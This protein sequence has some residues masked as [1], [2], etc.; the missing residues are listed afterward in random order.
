VTERALAEAQS[1]DGE[2]HAFIALDPD[3][4]RKAARRADEAR[5]RGH[6]LRPLHGVPL[7][8]KDLVRT[9]KLPTTGGS[10]TLGEGLSGERE[11][12]LVERLRSAGAVI[13]GKTNL[14]EFAYGV[15][16]ENAHFGD[17][18]N[19]WDRG[20]MSG[21]SSGGSAV[22]V[23]AGI[24]PGAVGTDTRG[25]IRIPASCCGITGFKPTRGRIPT[26]GVIP[27]SRSM[28]HVGPMARSVED[29]S[30]LYQVMAGG[31]EP[32]ERHARVMERPVRGL[33][34]GLSPYFRSGLHPDVEGAFDGAL[35]VLAELGLE[36]LEVAIPELEGSLGSSAVIAA[37]EALAV[38]DRRMRDRREAF[39]PAVLARLERGR[40]LTALELAR[41]LDHRRALSRAYRRVF[42]KVD[43]MVTPTLP[44]LPPPSGS[45]M[46]EAAGG[47]E[48]ILSAF[49][50]LLAPQNMT[51]TPA[52]S[53]PCGFSGTGLPIGLQLCAA[54]GAGE[55]ALAAGRAFQDVTDW[56]RHRPPPPV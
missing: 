27:L 2:L 9:R 52:L 13:L 45:D 26:H 12:R 30:L 11:A 54:A 50:R 17:T 1:L 15:T 32:E 36:V 7:G 37:A 44:G 47:E 5:T 34:V 24:V 28:D 39:D 49:C 41:A 8:I 10:R 18:P 46:V 43:L 22:A 25:S 42:Q 16:G 6:A 4:A 38:H 51:G 53:I 21:G 35:Q 56:H 14:N 31:R 19:P 40:S 20:R 23:S 48:G 33:R 55:L 3:G 29:V